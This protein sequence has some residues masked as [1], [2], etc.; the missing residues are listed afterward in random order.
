MEQRPGLFK[1]HRGHVEGRRSLNDWHN[2]Q[3]N[4]K[5]RYYPL[6]MKALAVSDKVLLVCQC[7]SG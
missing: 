4:K 6:N 2:Q 3:K 1:Y 7:G 5:H